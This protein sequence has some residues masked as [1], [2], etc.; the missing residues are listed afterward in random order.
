MAQIWPVQC[1]VLSFA[2]PL[3]TSKQEVAFLGTQAP[4]LHL[5][6]SVVAAAQA[7]Q[8]SW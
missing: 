3:P 7:E 8:W 1:P 5:V 4:W 2:S 6:P